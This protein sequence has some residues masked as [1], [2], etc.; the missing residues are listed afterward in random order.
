MRYCDKNLTPLSKRGVLD[1]AAH[2]SHLF[3]VPVGTSPRL[4]ND[5]TT[6]LSWLNGF[7]VRHS[8]IDVK[9]LQGIE[10][11]RTDAVTMGHIGEHI[12][13]V[14]AAL[15]RYNIREPRFIFNLDESGASFKK[16]TGRSLRKAVTT[17]SHTAIAVVC[18]TKGKLDHITVM[19]VAN[20]AWVTLKY[21]VV[22]PGREVHHRVVNRVGQFPQTFLPL[23]KFY[24]RD[25]AGVD[26]SIF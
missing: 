11:K 1:L 9:P 25:P 5:K 18:R 12:S 7:L 10:C 13:R 2:V 6:S 22:Y 15:M 24:L 26:S 4:E 3:P 21:V 16:V 17:N 23:C 8:N 20:S 19:S 14:K